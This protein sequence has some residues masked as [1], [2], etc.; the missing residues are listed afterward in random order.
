MWIRERSRGKQQQCIVVALLIHPHHPQ[1]WVI[2][3]KGVQGPTHVTQCSLPQYLTKEVI[4]L[5]SRQEECFGV[6]D[7]TADS[8][9]QFEA[10][11]SFF[12]KNFEAHNLKHHF[13]SLPHS[14]FHN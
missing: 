14:W 10:V 4:V 9:F 11:M 6:E 3:S 1:V 13:D 8:I 5:S 2:N 12:D 7:R